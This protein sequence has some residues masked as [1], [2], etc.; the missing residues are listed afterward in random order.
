MKNKL[1]ELIKMLFTRQSNIENQN[2]NTRGF[3]VA[4][5]PQPWR[6]SMTPALT[7]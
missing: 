7:P 1:K 4:G 3:F 5:S 6:Y 2:A